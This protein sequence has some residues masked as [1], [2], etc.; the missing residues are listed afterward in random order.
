LLKDIQHRAT[1][2]SEAKYLQIIQEL[3]NEN[4]SLK[5]KLTQTQLN[6]Q[7]KPSIQIRNIR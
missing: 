2:N 4:S 1:L 3:K 5:T 7:K 6:S